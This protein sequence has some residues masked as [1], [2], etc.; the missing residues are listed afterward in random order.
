[1][2]TPTLDST[3]LDYTSLDYT[4]FDADNHYYEVRDSFTR[5]L[6][7]RMA[8]RAVQWVEIDG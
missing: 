5:H 1:M 6:D 7:P 8:S 2:K 3:S 4:A